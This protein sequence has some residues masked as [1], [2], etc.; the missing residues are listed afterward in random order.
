MFFSNNFLNWPATSY[1]NLMPWYWNLLNRENVPVKFNT[2][3]TALVSGYSPS[4]LKA[5]LKNDMAEFTPEN[6]MLQTVCIPR[7]NY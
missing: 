1:N 5:I 4:I 7:Y 6:I 3:G 2:N